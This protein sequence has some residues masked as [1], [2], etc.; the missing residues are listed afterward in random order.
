MSGVPGR[1]GHVAR[2]PDQKT[3]YSALKGGTWCGWSDPVEFLAVS[4]PAVLEGAPWRVY[5][6]YRAYLQSGGST[7]PKGI[8]G[9]PAVCTP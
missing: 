9:T 1:G 3:F 7:R 6:Y 2:R 5:C 8:T 4:R